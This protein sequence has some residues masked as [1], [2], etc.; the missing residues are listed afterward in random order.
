M[1]RISID[2]NMGCT[3]PK[4][5]KCHSGVALMADPERAEAMVRATVAAVN[6]P[7][8]VKLRTGWRDRGESAVEFARRCER[9]GAAVLAVHPRWAGPALPR[10]CGLLGDRGSEAR[11]ERFPSSATATSPAPRMPCAWWR[12]PGATA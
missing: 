4:V 11:G 1:A 12:R 10:P 7:V 9:A 8:A 3:V 5:L 2:I 6:I